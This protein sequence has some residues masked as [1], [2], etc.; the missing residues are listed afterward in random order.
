VQASFFGGGY[1]QLT[2]APIDW[3][4]F[5]VRGWVDLAGWGA[6]LALCLVFHRWISP[7]TIY[8]APVLAAI[9]LAGVMVTG[10]TTTDDS[11]A[12]EAVDPAL[13]A[14]FS[15]TR[16]VLHVL[17]D[18]F[19]TGTFLEIVEEEGLADQF[20]G[21][22]VFPE[23]TGVAAYTAM[24]LPAIFSGRPY[25]GKETPAEYHHRKLREGG[26][27][28]RL[29]DE[30]Y[31]VHLIPKVPMDGEGYTLYAETPHTY[32]LDRAAGVR[33]QALFMLDLGL[34]RSSPH[35]LRRAIYNG[36]NW[37]LGSLAG[38]TK[39]G[40]NTH[41][42]AFFAAFIDRFEVVY[43]EPAYH[44]IHLLPPHDPFVTLSDG[45]DAG[46]I[47]PTNHENYRIEAWYTLKLFLELLQRLKNEGI[48]DDTL[49]VLHA[50]HG[51]G[52][53][54]KRAGDG[55]TLKIPRAAA[56]LAVKPLAAKGALKISDAP[57][58]VADIP[59]TIVS[60]LGLDHRYPG[61]SV[62][63]LAEDES[64]T[65]IFNSYTLG[66]KSRGVI[67]RYQLDGS[68][69]DPGAWRELGEQSVRLG[70]PTYNWGDVVEFG[71]GHDSDRY[72]GKNWSAG[73]AGGCRANTWKT[74]TLTLQV[75]PTADPV[76]ARFTFRLVHREGETRRLVLRLNIQGKVLG[77]GAFRDS[78]PETFEFV[79]PAGSV[80]RGRLALEFEFEDLDGG[81]RGAVQ[82]FC[83]V[84]MELAPV[85]G[86]DQVPANTPQEGKQ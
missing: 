48:Y 80:G 23:N 57:T 84:S 22:T 69:Y 4:L 37:R 36:G 39:K 34:F 42:R 6:M 21:F 68:L 66:T 20:E 44:F 18:G 5:T 74:G 31:A 16:N 81:R 11:A 52:D 82:A 2:G 46:E 79:L 72:L 32:G 45:S 59:A 49:I 61:S 12:E 41:Q 75:P 56:L 63:L 58:T 13:L 8:A 29:H 30:G 65:R 76:T 54:G 62:F 78:E 19:Q 17:L 10:V 60:G 50:D 53:F 15:R 67:T 73:G 28:H 55:R 9:I 40:L 47:L 38:E 71:V 7:R 25:D 24:S 77:E 14:K 3:S 1:G 70:R 26:F 43:E 85:V 27:H 64:R 86:N 35:F 51:M 33:Q 83:L